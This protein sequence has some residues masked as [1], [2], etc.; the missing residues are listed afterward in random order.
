MTAATITNKVEVNDPVKE[1]V[2]LTAT[3]TETYVSRKFST[4]L[5]V[6]ATF[7]EDL[8]A[9]DLPISCD[10]SGAT[11]TINCTG[12]TDKLICLV[13]YGRK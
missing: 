4:V 2:V 5:A 1:V 7:N 13:L 12:V 10:V 11:V 6:Q 9:L 8:G 3:D